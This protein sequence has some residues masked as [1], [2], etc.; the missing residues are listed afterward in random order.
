MK[1]DF[2]D[3]FLLAMERGL[4]PG[5]EAGQTWLVFNAHPLPKGALAPAQV[6]AEQGF[7]PTFNAIR[8]QG[9]DVEPSFRTGIRGDHAVV[10]ASRVRAVNEANLVRAWQATAPGGIII[11]AGDKSSGI[12]SLRKFAASKMTVADSF[13]KHHAVCFWCANPSDDPDLGLQRAPSPVF[14]GGEVDKGS[15]MLATHFTERIM[16]KVADFGAGNGFL[17]QA[18]LAGS[19]RIDAV[20][21]M[22]AEWAALEL[23]KS[24]LAGSNVPLAFHWIDIITELRKKPY[25]WVIMNPPFHHG[26]HGSAKPDLELGRRF[27]SQA[28]A[29]LIPGGRLLMVANRKLAY[30]RVLENAFHKAATLEERDGYKVIEATR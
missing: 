9:I 25:D 7:R 30:E 20:D 22:E 16:G 1:P 4:L 18:L 29:T 19:G 17:T 12:A 10:F 27:I 2:R 26:L 6:R 21:L 8:Q 28:A 11:V 3:T 15:A 13:S 5:P 23:A 24:R 14:A